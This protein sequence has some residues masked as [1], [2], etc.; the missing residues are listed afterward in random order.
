MLEKKKKSNVSIGNNCP[1][2]HYVKKKNKEKKI[3][4][5][6][7]ERKGNKHKKTQTRNKIFRREKTYK[8]KNLYWKIKENRKGR[9]ESERENGNTGKENG[10][11]K[12][13]EKQGSHICMQ[14]NFKV[15]LLGFA[16]AEA[17]CCSVAEKLYRV[18]CTVLPGV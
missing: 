4:K 1:I 13:I 2:I 12:R 17:S 16:R 7:N 11:K 14:M 5:I 8:K 9:P 15:V 10:K 18:S 3:E 6:L